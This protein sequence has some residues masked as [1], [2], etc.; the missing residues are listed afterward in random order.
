[1]H[2][3]ALCRAGVR[4]VFPQSC[5]VAV[6]RLSQDNA[7]YRKKTPKDGLVPFL[8]LSNSFCAALL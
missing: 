2:P 6:E 5:G 8:E 7:Q 1:M 3:V 4:D